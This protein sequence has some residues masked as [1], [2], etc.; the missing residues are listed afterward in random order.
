M[1]AAGLSVI[2][3][4]DTYTSELSEIKPKPIRRSEWYSS[5]FQCLAR[6][7]GKGFLIGASGW[8]IVSA[9]R[10]LMGVIRG[11]KRP[12]LP[13]IFNQYT[14][15]WGLMFG[16]TLALFNGTMYLT[17]QSHGDDDDDVLT[18]EGQLVSRRRTVLE[19]LLRLVHH[20][21]GVLAGGFC[22]LGMLFGPGDRETKK[23]LA[24]FMF[25]R[26]A[27]VMVKVWVEK[28][29]LPHFE[30]ADVLLMSL[31]S[32]QVK[33]RSVMQEAPRFAQ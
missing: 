32:A 21:R 22:G 5:F 11:S 20:Y 7:H 4:V 10:A 15:D 3:R 14:T 1:S 28:G 26:A 16:S 24:L 29:W 13:Q 27:E 8:A 12:V 17:N 6:N 18:D 23:T 19:T 31:A 25:M 33:K 30:N 9:S 2:S